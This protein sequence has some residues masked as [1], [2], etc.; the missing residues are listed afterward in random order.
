LKK[1]QFHSL[2]KDGLLLLDG[3]TGTELQ[4]NGL[5]SGISPEKWVLDNPAAL[6][7][8]QQG[9]FNAGSNAVLSF[10][11]GGNRPKLEE[12]GLGDT[13][14]EINRRLV[15]ISRQAAGKDGLVAG[16]I[17]S[18]GRFIEPFGDLPFELAVSYYKEQVAGLIEGGVDFFIIETM[19]DIQEARAALI[20]VKETCDLPVCVSMTFNEDG[21]TL[22]G[23][24]PVSALI[25]LQSL[26]AD[27]VGC[28]C[29]TGPEKMV[30]FIRSMRPYSK[31]PLLAKP[32]AGLP[33]LINART[34]FDMGPEEF[35]R[36]GS[37]LA[38]TGVSLIGG[39]CGT[40]PS[41]IME[42]HSNLKGFKP[43]PGTLPSFSAITS[44]RKTVQIG[45]GFPVTIIGERINPTGRKTLQDELME[46][47]TTEARR[48]AMEQTARGAAILDINVGMPGIN[49]K[50]K[51]AELVGLLATCVDAP[52]C[53]DSS[54]TDVLESAL[55][56]YPGRAL[57]NSISAEKTKLEKLL[58][59]AAKYGAMFILLPLDDKGIPETALEREQLVRMICDRA[60]EY[61]FTKDDIIVDGL[62]MTVSADQK[63]AKETLELIRWCNMEFQVNA[64]IGLSNISFGL[65]ERSQINNAFLAMAIGAGI[66]AVIANP[67]SEALIQVKMASDVLAGKDQ[68][69]L[70]YIAFHS[71][72][73]RSGNAVPRPVAEQNL[74]E[75]ISSA[76]VDGD[77]EVITSLLQKALA[78]G[79]KPD[80]LANLLLI[81]AITKVG[82]LFEQKKY[83]LPQLLQSAE[84]MKK[85]FEFLEPLMQDGKADAPAKTEI[86]LATVKGDIHDIGKNIIVL[87][88]RNY[89]FIVHDLG[90]DVE[91][92][93]IIDKARETG[94]GIIGLSALMTTTMVQMKSVIDL[95]RAEGLKCRF[96][97]GGAVVNQ[98]YA[99]EIGAAYASDAHMAVKM[100]RQLTLT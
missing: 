96:L 68:N 14:K 92:R 24:D 80:A 85:A 34:V 3:A 60:R 11:F 42:L 36:Y 27:A 19:I 5:P 82:E 72:G 16:D 54:D 20:A 53:L 39:C 93:M 91:A 23:T 48:L 37:L 73:T 57:I 56:I 12:Y 30:C 44:V 95:A 1:D 26:G 66:T 17:S 74:L 87:M 41:Y 64:L 77:R 59:V 65:P 90:K 81:P 49:E 99:D 21:R 43:A 52:L 31:V 75:R 89:G 29:S 33:K 22:T 10:T 100:A 45:P 78:D 98:A 50:Q 76:I 28:N 62:V 9:Y 88:L 15:L 38:E 4:K 47:K 79:H 84:A 18:T 83:F 94:A 25:T 70:R 35:G 46:G 13:V 51:M 71:D 63:A 40:S 32:N 67:A 7:S 61:A 2:L 97:I 69:C 8:L 6:V 55:R 58:P 86:V